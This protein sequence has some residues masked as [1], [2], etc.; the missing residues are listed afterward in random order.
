MAKKMFFV[1]LDTVEYAD[2]PF[3]QYL[4]DNDISHYLLEDIGPGGGNNVVRYSGVKVALNA[5]ITDHWQD[6]WLLQYVR[7]IGE[8]L[9]PIWCSFERIDLAIETLVAGHVLDVHTEQWAKDEG[10]Y[11]MGSGYVY[12]DTNDPYF[13]AFMDDMFNTS[14]K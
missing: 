2:L 6:A 8:R 9:I 4:E 12:K 7:P 13:I 5:M 11:I 14:G 3:R 10:H 1:D